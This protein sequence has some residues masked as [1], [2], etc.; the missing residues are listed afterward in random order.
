MTDLGCGHSLIVLCSLWVAVGLR[1]GYGATTLNYL[2]T[3]LAALACLFCFAKQTAHTPR[4]ERVGFG[5][6][7]FRRVF[8]SGEDLVSRQ[9]SLIY[10]IRLR[11]A[12]PDGALS[13]PVEETGED[14]RGMHLIKIRTRS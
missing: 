12:W 3:V 1:W 8:A 4:G 14:D 13:S 6:L 11:C 9:C 5:R 7:E 2:T 10:P